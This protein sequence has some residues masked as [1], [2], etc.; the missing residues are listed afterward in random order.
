MPFGTAVGETADTGRDEAA[1]G[2]AL[3]LCQPGTLHHKALCQNGQL[4]LWQPAD[5]CNTL[6]LVLSGSHQ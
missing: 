3:G 2:V 4:T 6:S 5:V 1:D